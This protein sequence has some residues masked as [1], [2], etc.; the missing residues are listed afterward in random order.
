M[1]QSKEQYT[2]VGYDKDADVYV[3]LAVIHCDLSVAISVADHM[4][5]LGLRRKDGDCYDW[6]EVI[7]PHKDIRH[8]VVQ[9]TGQSM[10]NPCYGDV[11]GE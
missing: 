6:I 5:T 7:T 10:L 11:K 1:V 8:H 3:Q 4:A 2:I 9:C